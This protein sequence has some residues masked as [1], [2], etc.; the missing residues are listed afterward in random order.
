MEIRV[1]LAKSAR[2]APE[3]LSNLTL[4][5]VGGGWIPLDSLGRMESR[6]VL[7]AITRRDRERVNTIQGFVTTGTL[8][9]EVSRD[10][11]A[12][13]AGPDAPALPTGTRIEAGGDA[14]TQADAVGNLALYVPILVILTISILVLSFRSVR[15]AIILCVAAF[16]SVGFG[17]LATWAAGF[18][19]SFNTFLGCLGLIGLAYNSSIVVIASIR[20]QPAARL[21]DPASMVAAIAG[22]GRHLTS[23]TLTTIG[24][25]L[26]LLLV[27]GGDFWPPLAI[28]L[29]GG[30]GGSTLLALVFT[31]AL[32]RRYC[33]PHHRTTF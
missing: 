6:P 33:I 30:V 25:C 11:L 13:L 23:T 27:V 8:P 18:P 14:E 24:G 26:P 19:L 9:I 5:S 7:G 1:R 31:P 22:C 10:I 3:D 15:I 16:L 28:V 20:E 12:H 17:L 29:V 4:P 32:Y 2:E 21:G